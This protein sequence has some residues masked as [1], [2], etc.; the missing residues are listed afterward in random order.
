MLWRRITARDHERVAAF[1]DERTMALRWLVA[2]FRRQDLFPA[3][4]AENWALWCGVE[5]DGGL[6]CVAAHFFPSATTYVAA[7][8]QADPR[9]FGVLCAEEVLP[10]KVIGDRELIDRWRAAEPE[11]FAK[12]ERVLEIDVLVAAEAADESPP[13][14]FRAAVPA[15]V[16]LLEEFGRLFA[17]ESGLEPPGDFATLVAHGLVFV[18]EAEGK[19]LGFVRSNLSD[20]KHVHGGGLYV[21]PRHRGHGVAR[22]LARGLGAA[23]R[24]A[25][26]G[27]AVLDVHRENQ[28]AQRAYR[29]AGYQPAGEGL[30]VRFPEDAWE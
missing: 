24:A 17:V 1:L 4:E 11:V 2:F 3:E 26:G 18:F 15:D 9:A 10:E 7:S 30:E 16:P 23:V 25:G 6:S 5:E 8:A 27:A 13:A 22:A 28:P 20:G 12:T 21:H 19:V 29:A 14:G